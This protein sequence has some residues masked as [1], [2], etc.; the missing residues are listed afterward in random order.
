MDFKR[1]LAGLITPENVN[2][3]E[4]YAALAPTPDISK[5]DVCLPCFKFSK[6]LRKSPQ[7]IAEELKKRLDESECEFVEKSAV[8]GG[9]LNIFYDRGTCIDYWYYNHIYK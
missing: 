3:D 5:G 1:T 9:Y 7:A 6:A 8:E 4:V 2:C